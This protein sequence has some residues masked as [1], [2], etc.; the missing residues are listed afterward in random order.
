MI[1]ISEDIK[2]FNIIIYDKI[3]SPMWYL[4]LIKTKLYTEKKL[5]NYCNLKRFR[6]ILH[7]KRD[8]MC[9][10]FQIEVMFFYGNTFLVVQMYKL[11]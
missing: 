9:S 5:E 6:P 2:N 4:L 3:I 1:I 11:Y 10:G 7:L 8:L